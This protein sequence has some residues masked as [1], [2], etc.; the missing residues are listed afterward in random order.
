MNNH[1]FDTIRLQEALKLLDEQLLLV[2]APATGLVICGGSALI[3]TGLVMR[4]TRDIDILAFWDNDVLKDS[5][6]PS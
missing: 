4:T 6:P 3:A 2:G 5:D 1:S